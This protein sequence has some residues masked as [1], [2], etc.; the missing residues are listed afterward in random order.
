MLLNLIRYGTNK[1]ATLCTKYWIRCF[2]NESC[3]R[4]AIC[5]W[6][7]TLK[8]HHKKFSLIICIK[9]AY[10]AFSKKDIQ[11]EIA[12]SCTYAGQ[13]FPLFPP[14]YVKLFE[15]HE[16]GGGGSVRLDDLLRRT[17]DLLPKDQNLKPSLTTD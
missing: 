14:S 9:N 10:L 16:Y 7:D 6:E 11:W 17:L 15:S 13:C 12:Y 1:A 2:K 3:W 5:Q 8:M 4:N